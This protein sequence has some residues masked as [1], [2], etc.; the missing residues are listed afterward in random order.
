MATIISEN[1]YPAKRY[2]LNHRITGLF[3]L[4]NNITNNSA[5]NMKYEQYKNIYT[6]QLFY[7]KYI[8]MN[9]NT[10]GFAEK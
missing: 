1:I 10:N 7:A 9:L 4:Y 3:F 2:N 5:D 8:H 6:F